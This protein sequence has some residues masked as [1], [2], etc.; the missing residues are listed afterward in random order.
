M[1]SAAG[2]LSYSSVAQLLASRCKVLSLTLASSHASTL[3]NAL[4]AGFVEGAGSLALYVSG[5]GRKRVCRVFPGLHNYNNLLGGALL[6]DRLQAKATTR[7]EA[8]ALTPDVR[9][10]L[11][12]LDQLLADAKA[13]ASQFSSV[14]RL[15]YLDLLR[16]QWQGSE[17]PARDVARVRLDPTSRLCPTAMVPRPEWQMALPAGVSTVVRLLW[18]IA[19]QASF[20]WHRDTEEKR[21]QKLTLVY[22]LSNGFSSMHVAGAGAAAPSVG[23]S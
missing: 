11:P 8:E 10:V 16:Q 1:L 9:A 20:G 18:Q 13:A 17:V 23:L 6:D 3:A 7:I 12:G 5:R 14:I 21:E 2:G 22:M 4:V 15:L 19:Q